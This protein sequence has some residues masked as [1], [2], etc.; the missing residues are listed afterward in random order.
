[1]GWELAH[2]RNISSITEQAHTLE[3]T[4]VLHFDLMMTVIL[5]LVV[6]IIYRERSS[7][8]SIF[9][10]LIVTG[11]VFY[12]FNVIRLA[13]FPLPINE[14]YIELLKQEVECGVIIER[15]HNLELFDFMKWGNLF[16]ITTVG[17]FL[18]LLPLSFFCPL[19]YRNQKWGIIKITLT[20]FL[21]SLTIEVLQLSYDLLTGYAYRGFNVDD[22]F[23]NTL[24][25]IVGFLIFTILKIFFGMTLKAVRLFVN[26]LA[27]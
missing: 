14:E 27:G 24:G 15:R 25:V 23:M 2:C 26:R 21:V 6:M 4:S 18:L 8:K 9:S 13:F 22:L 1:M 19:V 17:N 7:E 16:H 5:T 10:F 11:F 20:G 3:K 12:I